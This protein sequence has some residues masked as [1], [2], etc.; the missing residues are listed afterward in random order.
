MLNRKKHR[1]CYVHLMGGLGNQLFQ[2]AAGLHHS[3]K[4]GCTLVCD[5]SSESIRRNDSGHA[6]VLS[7]QSSEYSH[8]RV[9]T[10]YKTIVEKFTNKILR[11][12]LSLSSN[13]LNS[14]FIT[15]LVYIQS[16]LLSLHFRRIVKVWSAKQIGYEPI[17]FCSHTNNYLI[18]YF[19]T[20]KYASEPRVNSILR[21]LIDPHISIESYQDL[22]RLE[23][24]LIVHIRL[25]DYINEPNFG[26]I[27]KNYYFNSV[28]IMM[29]KYNF[30]SI[31]VF[32]D[33]IETA[34]SFIPENYLSICR[35]MDGKDE[36]SI[37][38]LERMRCGSAYIIGNSTF[39]WWGSFLSHSINPPTIAPEPWFAEMDDPSDLIPPRWIRMRR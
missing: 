11:L 16:I 13:R 35:W 2:L 4:Y 25:G 32:S 19:Q 24:P 33:D 14:Y 6:D 38:T 9:Q 27:S 5:E 15:L 22:C 39:G 8:T 36:S 17:K 28:S 30:I 21:A 26:I 31:H 1:N 34:K 3:A 37:T 23:K 10:W 29:Q 20:Y 18:G 12:S 7:Y